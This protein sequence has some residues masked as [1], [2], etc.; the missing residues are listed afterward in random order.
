MSED[1]ILAAS[2]GMP[3][4]VLFSVLVTDHHTYAEQTSLVALIVA[5]SVLAL[6]AAVPSLPPILVLPLAFIGLIVSIS[7]VVY[8][9][10][11]RQPTE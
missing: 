1:Y 7:G 10:V 11:G 4:V 8:D 6:D 3:A 5:I 9:H 2:F